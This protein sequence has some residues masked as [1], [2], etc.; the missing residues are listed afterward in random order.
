M[1]KLMLVTGASRGIGRAIA[2]H[3][4]SSYQVVT[5]SRSGDTTEKGDL[6]DIEFRK[7]LIEKYTPDVFVN[8]AGILS[9]DFT[10]TFN[11]NVMAMGHLLTAFYKKMTSGSI[12]NLSSIAAN[13]MGWEGMPDMRVHYLASKKA[14]KDLSNHLNASKNKPVRVMSIEPDHVNTTIGNGPLYDVDYEIAGPVDYFSP[15]PPEYIAEVMEWMLA[16]PPYVVISSIEIS[17]IHRKAAQSTA[18]KL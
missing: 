11:I 5:V 16:Q 2:E 18:K 8:C 7:Y 6:T 9:H 1:G 10:D 14:L 4:A 13:K 3:F 15:M 12:I 17:N